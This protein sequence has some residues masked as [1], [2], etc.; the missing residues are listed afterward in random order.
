MVD[1]DVLCLLVHVTV[2]M[3]SQKRPIC[4]PW[5]VSGM[6]CSSMSHP[7]KIPAISRSFMESV[8]VGFCGEMS[9]FWMCCGHSNLHTHCV[10]RFCVPF[11]HTPPTADLEESTYPI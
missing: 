11:V 5:I 4:E 6:M 2:D 1:V 9:K 8:P 3:L 10:D 7:N